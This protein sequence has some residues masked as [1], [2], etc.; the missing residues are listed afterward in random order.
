MM[1][2]NIQ[3]MTKMIPR[4][5]RDAEIGEGRN[6]EKASSVDDLTRPLVSTKRARERRGTSR[7]MASKLSL[8]GR[9]P[10]LDPSLK[11]SVSIAKEMVTRN[12]TTPN[13]WRIRRMAK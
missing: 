1:N 9:I 2:Y 13:I 7:K 12:G 8:P 6:Q 3:G 10:S 5:L 4:A 11:L